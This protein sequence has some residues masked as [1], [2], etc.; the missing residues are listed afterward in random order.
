MIT[1]DSGGSYDIVGSVDTECIGK[2]SATLN[3]VLFEIYSYY[4]GGSLL[5]A[6]DK[7]F[8][9]PFVFIIITLLVVYLMTTQ[10]FRQQFSEMTGLVNALAPLPDSMDQIEALE[11]REDDAEEVISV[12]NS[13]A[14]TKD[15]ETERANKLLSLTSYDQESDSIKNMAIIESNSSQYLAMG[16][17]KLCGLEVAETVFGV[18]EYN[19]IVRRLCQR[20][21]GKY[22]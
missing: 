13:I 19:K 22:V 2:T 4:P 9:L 1:C 18:D 11:T 7:L 12:R 14:E 3:N 21:A 5:D 8:Y 16:I 6:P 10:V 20:I 15:A 17:I